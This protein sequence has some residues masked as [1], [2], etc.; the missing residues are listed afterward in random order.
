MRLPLVLELGQQCLILIITF[1]SLS[2][3][4]CHGVHPRKSDCC[5]VHQA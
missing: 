2:R 5:G 1:S 4:T 3:L